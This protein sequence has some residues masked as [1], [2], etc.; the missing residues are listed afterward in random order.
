MAT[1]TLPYELRS[2]AK[3]T[4]DVVYGALFQSAVSTLKDFGQNH[5][6]LQARLGLTAVLHTHSRR[7]NYH[8]HVHVMV[9]GGGVHTARREWRK[10][11]GRYLFNGNALAR[12]FRARMLTT[13]KKQGMTLPV[14]PDRWVVQCQEVGYGDSA[15][16]YLSRYLYRGVI[17]DRQIRCDDGTHV[18]F[19]YTD[20]RTRTIKTRTLAGEDFLKLILQHVLPKGFR[21]VRDY[22]FLL[23]H[24]R[25]L[26]TT[27]QWILRVSITAKRRVRRAVFACPHCQQNMV[28][29]RRKLPKPQPG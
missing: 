4:P 19:E 16:R 15:I 18:T 3:K 11:K 12:V 26:L 29:I 7:L 2:L 25:T 23:G 20:S 22:G 24:A 8:P 6:D 28:I 17:S 27:I 14:T 1:F 10:L 9:P 5:P 13:L 21:R